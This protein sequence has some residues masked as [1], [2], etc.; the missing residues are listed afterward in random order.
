MRSTSAIFSSILLSVLSASPVAEDSSLPKKVGIIIPLTGDVSPF[1]EDIRNVS[2]FANEKLASNRLE[3]LFED[4]RCLGKNA[5]TAASKLL[6][7]DHIDYG[8]I[9]CT[10]PMQ[11]VAPLFES[12]KTLIITPLATGASVSSAGDYIFRTWP[13]DALAG[14]LLFDYVKSRHKKFALL[15]EERGYPQGLANSFI[16]AAK[17]SELILVKEDYLS[18]ETAFKTILL[19][20]KSAGLD[21]LMINPDGS[22][23][24]L[25]ILKMLRET[26]M[27]IPLYGVYMPGNK[28]FLNSAGV[29]A[30]GI[31]FV[32]GPSEI[33]FNSDGK[34]LL[35]EFERRFGP[36]HSTPFIFGSTFEAIRLMDAISKQKEDPRKFLYTG[37]FE[38]VFG[39]YSFDSNG[40]LVGP[41]HVLK[42]I[43]K[44]KAEL[45][46]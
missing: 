38:G 1:G 37:K 34:N 39:P 3:L 16:D 6:H 13:S 23:S 28:D 45:L 44:G 20:L 32:D 29:Q 25:T 41:R 42:I 46:E 2:I 21:G 15:S 43:R 30:D 7:S 18:G 5:V 12:Q 22:G 26:R 31:I 27:N 33:S 24:L 40:D 11:S 10:E 19:K 36:L 17:G 9:G 35:S 14:K 4:D 8:M